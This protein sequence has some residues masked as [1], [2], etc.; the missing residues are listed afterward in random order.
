MKKIFSIILCAALLLTT[1]A[2]VACNKTEE[3]NADGEKTTLKLGLGVYTDVSKASNADGDTNGQGQAATT[4]A[5]VLVDA[6]GKIVKCVLDTA[7][8]TVSYTSDGKAIAVESFKTKYELGYDYNMKAYGA[9]KEWFEH[10][11]A[12]CALVVG[13]TVSEVKALVAEGDKGND[14]VINAG[15]TIK[16]NEFVLAIEKAVANAADSA[17]TADS[18]LKLGV[19]TVQKTADATEEK[20]GEN[21]IEVTAFAAAVGA[22]GKIVAA[23]SDC[24]QIKFT[25]DNK[26][27]STYDLTKT[28]ETKKEKGANYG[29]AA[30]GTDLN[31][32]GVVKEWNEQAKIFDDACIGK[33]ASEIAGLMV[34][35]YGSADLQSAGCTVL[36]NGFVAAAS[37]IG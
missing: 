3:P 22:D 19:A 31:G 14:E 25:F 37:K 28:V 4:A 8:N 26:G 33:T 36:V 27:V 35:N 11:D 15:C 23:S 9:A 20:A 1:L 18:A 10:A 24:A 21:Q 34:D 13:K 12:F 32:D 7:D 5:A 6:D 17:A 16:I 2:F 29:M 30:Y